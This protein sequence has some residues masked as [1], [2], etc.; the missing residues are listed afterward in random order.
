MYRGLNEWPIIPPE[1]FRELAHI[2]YGRAF[3][4]SNKIMEAL[5]V[6]LV[7]VILSHVD[8][9]TLLCCSAVSH[10]WT[11][12]FRRHLRGGSRPAL[13]GKNDYMATWRCCSGH[14]NSC[15]ETG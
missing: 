6:E 12:A 5:P 8:E 2:I 11:T 9:L 10:C 15:P 1:D 3:S 14:A 7:G 4:Q 13:V